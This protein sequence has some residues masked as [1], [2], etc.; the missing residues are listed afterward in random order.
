MKNPDAKFTGWITKRGPGY[1]QAVVNI[2]R[3]PESPGKYKTMSKSIRGSKPEA[4][5]YLREWLSRLEEA[6]TKTEPSS[7]LLSEWLLEWVDDIAQNDLERNTYLSYRWEIEKHIIP[8]IGSAPISELLPSDL[9]KFY[10]YKAKNGRITSEGGL[11]NR[12][13][14]YIH[15]I[16]NQALKKAVELELIPKNPCEKV[17][18]PRD[19]KRNRK[20]ENDFIALD[21]DELKAFLNLCKGHRD[22][23]IIYIAAFTGA[24]QSEILGLRWQDVDWEGKSI[25]ISMT[26]HRYKKGLFEHR[27]R[28]KN[29]SSKRSIALTTDD[30]SVLKAQEIKQKEEKLA[31]GAGWDNQYDLVFT[32]A[33]GQPVDRHNLLTRFQT[34]ARHFGK[35]DLTFHGLRHTH[36]TILLSDG[37]YIN[38]VSERLGHSDV[39][40]TL[41]EYG[42]VLPKKKE[43][44]A[45]RFSRLLS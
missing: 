29:D 3:D 42:H 39:N 41:R 21:A 9:Q 32:E 14:I 25:N 23:N 24:R 40:T 27:P 16:L 30:M 26:M 4:Q 2:G 1:Y 5:A 34:L 20:S 22:Y 11:S 15:T 7:M 19:K 35:P 12:S 6:E 33:S 10:S 38:A 18:P 28:T 37:E 45:E 13:I 44:I 31:H 17:K 36:A 43:D 8:M